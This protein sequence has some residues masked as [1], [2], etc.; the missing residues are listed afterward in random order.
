VFFHFHV[1]VA[2]GLA[3]GMVTVGFF[4]WFKRGQFRLPVD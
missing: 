1:D 4:L 3:I 2:V